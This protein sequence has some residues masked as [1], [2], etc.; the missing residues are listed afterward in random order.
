MDPKDLGRAVWRHRLLVATIAIVTM[1]AVLAGLWLAPK[2][3][4]STATLTAAA[5]PD[6]VET[7]ENL[8]SLRGSLAELAN[9][10]DVLEEV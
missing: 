7:G 9:S 10:E 2:T 5:T 8:D 3:Y 6:A 4:E 1:G